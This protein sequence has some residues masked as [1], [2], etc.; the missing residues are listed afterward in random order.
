V[1]NAPD[2]AR[3]DKDTDML[4]EVV[5]DLLRGSKSSRDT[6]AVPDLFAGQTKLHLGCGT[7]VLPGWANID[8]DGPSEVLK[9]DLT[10]RLPMQPETVQFVFNEHFIE[11]ISRQQAVELLYDCH[12]LLIPD[13]VL[14]I[15]TPCLRKLIHEYLQ[16]RTTEWVDVQWH[17][18]TACQMMNE[19][20]RSWG[21]Q[22][23]YDA[24][25]LK[26]IL[27]DCGFKG[28]AEVEWRQSRHPELRNLECRPFHDEII[29]EAT[30]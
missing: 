1:T 19:G 16:G 2:A 27:R 25:E 10:Q 4:K 23:L 3:I 6:L 18:A 12:R 24:E 28:V 17:P 22:F 15:S 30:K 5:R 9:W 11:H 8:S 14:R 29:L 20:M 26:S 13:G 7:N 21:H